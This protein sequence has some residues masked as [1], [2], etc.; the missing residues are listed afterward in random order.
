MLAS[1]GQRW[2][3]C[4]PALHG[5]VWRRGLRLRRLPELPLQGLPLGVVGPPR[6]LSWSSSELPFGTLPAADRKSAVGATVAPTQEARWWTAWEV[7]LVLS[8]VAPGVENPGAFDQLCVGGHLFSV[9]CSTSKA[10]LEIYTYTSFVPSG[11]LFWKNFP[12]KTRRVSRYLPAAP[13]AP[14]SLHGGVAGLT[15]PPPPFP[16][17]SPSP[18]ATVPASHSCHLCSGCSSLQI[19]PGCCVPILLLGLRGATTWVSPAVGGQSSGGAPI[20]R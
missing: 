12:R 20:Q 11:F 1:A 7:G 6:P 13:P 16:T 4:L 3:P 10:V 17:L 2:R 8:R 5:A 15:P 18:T 14:R 19:G 9:F